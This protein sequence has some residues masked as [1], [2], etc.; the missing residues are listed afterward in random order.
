MI[1]VSAAASMPGR[2]SS[3]AADVQAPTGTCTSTGWSGWPSQTPC[4]RFFQRP[5]RSTLS[6]A[7]WTLS[8]SGSRT[9]AFSSESKGVVDMSLALPTWRRS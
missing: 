8:A 1:R 2:A 5:G 9:A 6:R 7:D 3:T 4:R